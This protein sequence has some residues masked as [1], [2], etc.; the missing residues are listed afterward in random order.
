MVTLVQPSRWVAYEVPPKA[1]VQANA[2]DY[3]RAMV[4]TRGIMRSSSY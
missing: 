4:F 1:H 2:H 3:S